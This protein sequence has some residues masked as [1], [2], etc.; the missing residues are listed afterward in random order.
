MLDAG[1]LAGWI[2]R[3]TGLLRLKTLL[4]WYYSVLKNYQRDDGKACMDNVFQP[5]E[6]ALPAEL[7]CA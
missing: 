6:S 4:E 3:M 1:E 7:S 5:Q 2:Q